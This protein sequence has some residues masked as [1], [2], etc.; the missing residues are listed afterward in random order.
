MEVKDH[1]EALFSD[2][3]LCRIVLS[4]S[5]N[6]I[7]GVALSPLHPLFEEK[8]VDVFDIVK[9]TKYS[10]TT[11]KGHF[12]MLLGDVDLAS[13]VKIDG[14]LGDPVNIESSVAAPQVGKPTPAPSPIPTSNYAAPP[15]SNYAP[16][17]PNTYAP[18]PMNNYAPPPAPM[19]NP[20]MAPHQPMYQ[21][22]PQP[23]SYAVP[24]PPVPQSS[25]YM[26]RP[27]GMSAPAPSYAPATL[28]NQDTSYA[29]RNALAHQTGQ[30]AGFS[31]NFGGHGGPQGG[32]PNL[33]TSSMTGDDSEV[34]YTPIAGLSPYQNVYVWGLSFLSLIYLCLIGSPSRPGAPSSQRS[35]RL[36]RPSPM[37][38]FSASTSLT[39]QYAKSGPISM[40]S[41]RYLG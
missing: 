26:G 22:P 41:H 24:P 16:P 31:S 39:S 29:P 30:A 2:C 19:L 21:A 7:Q 36:P 35:G 33:G 38:S 17:P 13:I 14:K 40:S 9:V 23:Q 34:I 11:L 27:A 25:T 1:L 18:P 10:M 12:I 20:Y 15:P 32:N 37:G 4:D 28:S 8:K 6:F 3:P 5:V